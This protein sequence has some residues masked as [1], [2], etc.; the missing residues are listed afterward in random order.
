MLGLASAGDESGAA[1]RELGSSLRART[2]DSV[3][4][5]VPPRRGRSLSSSGRKQQG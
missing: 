1:P 3:I 2:P 4:T 5:K